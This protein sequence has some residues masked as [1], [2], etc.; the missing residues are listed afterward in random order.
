ETGL[1]VSVYTIRRALKR[2]K[3]EM[4]PEHDIP[5]SSTPHS[6]AKKPKSKPSYIALN[7]MHIKR[8][9][10]YLKEDNSIESVEARNRLQEET[11]LDLNISSI[12]TNLK[13]LKKEM[14]L[15]CTKRSALSSIF[16]I[17]K[18]HGRMAKIK[19]HHLEYLS[20][21]LKENSSIEPNEARDRL[22][23]DTS[24]AVSISTVRST[25]KKLKEEMGLKCTEQYAPSSIFDKRRRYEKTSLIKS[26]HLE[27]IIK[28]LKQNS[29]IDPNEVKDKLYKD[30]CLKVG[31][32]A[33]RKNL[34]ALKKE[35]ENELNQDNPSLDS[36][37]SN[38][39]DD[40]AKSKY[41]S[42]LDSTQM[43]HPEDILNEDSSRGYIETRDRPEIDASFEAFYPISENSL[44][45]ST[46][47]ADIRPE[48][49]ILSS[50]A[51]S[52]RSSN[53]HKLKHVHIR[54]LKKYLGE[55]S[56]IGNIEA[57]NRFQIDTGLEL[58]V[59]TVEKYLSRLREE[60]GIGHK[61]SNPFISENM[62]SS[63]DKVLQGTRLEFLKTCFSEN[64]SIEPIEVLNKLQEEAGLE[65]NILSI[66]KTLK[67]LKEKNYRY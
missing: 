26:H 30:T 41:D 20:D 9:K 15:E 31:I 19:C 2:L 63:H 61:N 50:I 34:K 8:L 29:S 32:S 60:L 5:T 4:C 33:I 44:N 53:T 37:T 38:P 6:R 45:M 27:H 22:H 62:R 18:R 55:D 40:I 48:S 35:L 43:E 57:R 23:I 13:R 25:L 42:N 3:E 54:I 66:R 16:D 7:N 28:Y 39:R 24:L 65:A 46:Y 14:G 51:K 17:R 58:H 49:S 56:F 47:Q 11:G 64:S 21:Y 1:R 59:K 67:K 36:F 12:Y 52:S 10:D